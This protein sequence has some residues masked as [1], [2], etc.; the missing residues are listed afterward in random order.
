MIKQI[1]LI[2][3]VSIGLIILI[4]GT[5]VATKSNYNHPHGIVTSL[6]GISFII[7]ALFK[8]QQHKQ[9]PQIQF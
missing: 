1:C 3:L 2:V 6:D 7:G 5:N 8:F 4:P 9:N